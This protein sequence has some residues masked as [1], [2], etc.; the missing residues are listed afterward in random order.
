[1]LNFNEAPLPIQT[2]YPQTQFLKFQDSQ[3]IEKLKETLGQLPPMQTETTIELTKSAFL[4][5]KILNLVIL[6]LGQAVHRAK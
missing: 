3:Q 2:A 4:T 5:F 6:H 1:M